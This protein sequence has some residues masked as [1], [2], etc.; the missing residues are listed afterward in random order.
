MRVFYPTGEGADVTPWEKE[1]FAEMFPEGMEVNIENLD[2]LCNATYEKNGEERSIF[3][4]NWLLG[5]ITREYHPD[6][7]KAEDVFEEVYGEKICN[8]DEPDD[9]TPRSH[10]RQVLREAFIKAWNL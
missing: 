4:L 3:D 8:D 7:P 2:K 6:G 5:M 1:A 9:I 10:A